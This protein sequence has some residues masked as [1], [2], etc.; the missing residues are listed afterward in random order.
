MDQTPGIIDLHFPQTE[1]YIQPC[2]HKVGAAGCTG[3]YIQMT[4]AI[5][6][7]Q[8]QHKVL[9]AFK[10]TAEGIYLVRQCQVLYRMLETI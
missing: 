4:T 1:Y 9:G 8:I 3:Y 10:C 2:L 7:T 5:F 6:V